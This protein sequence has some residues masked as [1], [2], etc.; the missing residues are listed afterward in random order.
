M[1]QVFCAT[2]RCIFPR[3]HPIKPFTNKDI[4]ENRYQVMDGRTD[5]RT[6]NIFDSIKKLSKANSDGPSILS[7]KPLTNQP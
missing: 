3:F 7:S 4:A 1:K 6:D 2:N 5:G